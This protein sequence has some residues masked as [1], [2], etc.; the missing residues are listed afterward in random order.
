MNNLKVPKIAIKIMICFHDDGDELF[1]KVD[2]GYNLYQQYSRIRMKKIPTIN[3]DLTF[4]NEG[5]HHT[6]KND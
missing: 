1:F 4:L 2:F 3:A 6:N 5:A